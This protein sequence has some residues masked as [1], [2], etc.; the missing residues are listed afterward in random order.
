MR[1]FGKFRQKGGRGYIH[2]ACIH[3]RWYNSNIDSFY[4]GKGIGGEIMSERPIRSSAAEYLTYVASTG[5]DKESVEIRYEDEDIWLTQR[6][7]AALY[8]V[9]V[10]TVNSHIQT[11][12]K[13]RELR[14]GATIRKYQIVQQEGTRMV[15][16]D[17]NHYNLQMIIA[18]GFK[19][20]SERAVQ[21]RKW[22][23]Q[24][25]REYTIKGWVM[26]DE[27]LCGSS[28]P[29]CLDRV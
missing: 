27:R 16:R 17:V 23:N 21:F 7:M 14:E 15:H 1:C 19:V 11:I 26:D 10:K 12:L 2:L 25:A 5:A 28:P 24:V 22:V 20:N 9:D 3:D 6:M 8:Q 29:A 18:V 4:P 13:D